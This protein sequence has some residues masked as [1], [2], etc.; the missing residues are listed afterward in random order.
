MQLGCHCPA[1]DI[2]CSVCSAVRTL[3][4]KLGTTFGVMFIDRARAR[5]TTVA[6]IPRHTFIG[7]VWPR[8]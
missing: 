2:Q 1:Q 6:A 5:T 8:F 4:Y 7:M 3:A